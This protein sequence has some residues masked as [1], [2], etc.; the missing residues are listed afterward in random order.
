MRNPVMLGFVLMYI[1][2]HEVS[3]G[4]GIGC[5]WN[6]CI[7]GIELCTV[8]TK[9]IICIHDSSLN[10][11]LVGTIFIFNTECPVE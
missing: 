8:I 5:F 11:F 9:L 7:L 4:P 10:E 1:F 6:T 3:C 2:F